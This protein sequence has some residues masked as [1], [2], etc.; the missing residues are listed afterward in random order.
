MKRL[1]RTIDAI[2]WRYFRSPIDYARHIGVHIGE[3]C[4]I[5]IRKWS[6]EPYLVTIG[7]NVQVTHDVS[8]QTHGGGHC[9]RY[10]YPGFETFG[11]IVVE[12]WVYI[13]SHSIILPG[14]TIGFGSLIGAGSVVT[15]SVPPNSVVVGNPARF[16][17]T[18]Q[19]F[20]E[21]NKHLNTGTSELSDE[22]KKTILLQ[23]SEDMF[24][25]K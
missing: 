15:K 4:Q 22:E 18:T 16:I 17:C 5:S 9:V 23:L 25:R 6:T 21:K 19:E 12:D 20:Y 8:F 2:Y 3:G 24:V 10:K 7:N 13:G 14:C 1:I 11:R